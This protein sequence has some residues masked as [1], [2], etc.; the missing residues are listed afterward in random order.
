[1]IGGHYEGY[2]AALAAALADRRP[3]VFAPFRNGGPRRGQLAT[4]WMEFVA[5]WRLMGGGRRPGR[6]LVFP[7]PEFRDSV[8]SCCSGWRRGCAGHTAAW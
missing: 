2:L 4:Y 5:L 8:I 1:M 6:V 7:G 3:A